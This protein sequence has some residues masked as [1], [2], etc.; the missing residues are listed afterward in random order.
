MLHGGMVRELVFATRNP[1]EVL[2][3]IHERVEKAK[4]NT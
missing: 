3:V 2:G 4:G 1:D